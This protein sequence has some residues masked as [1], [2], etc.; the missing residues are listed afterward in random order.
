MRVG[1]GLLFLIGLSATGTACS[2]DALAPTGAGG[3]SAGQGGGGQSAGGAGPSP[4]LPCDATYELSRGT[5]PVGAPVAEFGLAPHDTAGTQ[6][7]F[8][9]TE[10]TSRLGTAFVSGTGETHNVAVSSV[11]I[12]DLT[13]GFGYFGPMAVANSAPGAGLRLLEPQS[14]FAQ[15]IL[16]GPNAPRFVS[17]TDLSLYVGTLVG[18]AL[19]L[20]ARVAPFSPGAD[21]DWTAG[22]ASTP[23]R[24]AA[25][26]DGAIPVFA[27]TSGS[28]W[29]SCD[30]SPTPAVQLQFGLGGYSDAPPTLHDQ[31]EL[32]SPAIGLAVF[33]RDPGY[34]IVAQFPDKLTAFRLS[35]SG[36]F[37]EDPLDI[38][39][40]S[41]GGPPAISSLGGRL[42]VG[43]IR[44][45][46]S[47][48]HTL[49]IRV[50]HP[51]GQMGI[52]HTAAIQSIG[53]QLAL[54]DD[55]DPAGDGGVVAI[56][57]T[58]EP[59]AP[60]LAVSHVLCA[61]GEF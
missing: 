50:V 26:I 38:P 46:A 47:G 4:R 44:S 24:A 11:E 28:P 55:G 18:D 59:S 39:L 34:W 36:K 12:H 20:S 21:T 22:C 16:A 7:V 53:D 25:T 30:A 56:W 57:R 54:G 42:A 31:R 41:D 15:E 61:V 32:E 3:G 49:S 19:V 10:D 40:W 43:Q 45:D 48:G 58:G 17:S 23:M 29:M 13:V 6:R 9:R 33:L 8:F 35:P 2:D 51:D 52:E 27:W 37:T 60:N 1:T 14:S 5:I